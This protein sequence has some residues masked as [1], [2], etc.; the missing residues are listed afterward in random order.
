M[1]IGDGEQ[2]KGRRGD[3]QWDGERGWE[4]FSPS[5]WVVGVSSDR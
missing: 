3:C 4:E 5:A 2:E 1:V